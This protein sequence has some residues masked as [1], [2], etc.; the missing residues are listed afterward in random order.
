[1]LQLNPDFVTK[2]LERFEAFKDVDYNPMA[3]AGKKWLAMKSPVGITLG[4]QRQADAEAKKVRDFKRLGK[5]TRIP[6][7]GKKPSE[8]LA[9]MADAMDD[10]PFEKWG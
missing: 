2:A 6:A 5:A 8:E 4:Q 7:A 3:E 10:I 1:M 9:A